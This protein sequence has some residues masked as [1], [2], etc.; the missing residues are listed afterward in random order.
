MI[1][2]YQVLLDYPRIRLSPVNLSDFSRAIEDAY[3][4]DLLHE[5]L[6]PHSKQDILD[7]VIERLRSCDGWPGVKIP[8]ELWTLR[9]KKL[10]DE[11]IING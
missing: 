3:A 1:K 11:A 2:S 7:C 8:L 5:R 6:D 10:H 4:D 9:R